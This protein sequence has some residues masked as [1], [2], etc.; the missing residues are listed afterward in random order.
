MLLS[1]TP[2]EKCTQTLSALVRLDD[3]NGVD[4][5]EAA[6][7]DLLEAAGSDSEVRITALDHLAHA[8]RHQGWNTGFAEIIFAYIALQRARLA[9]KIPL[10]EPVCDQCMEAF[11]ANLLAS[12]PKTEEERVRR[13][14]ERSA[15][16]PKPG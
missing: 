15:Q 10:R 8:V 4:F 6:V 7:G 5:M 16:T 9:G 3:V 1:M 2:L 11:S 12:F 13:R 14:A